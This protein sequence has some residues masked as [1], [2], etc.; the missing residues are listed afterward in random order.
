MSEG[1][2]TIELGTQTISSNQEKGSA[3]NPFPEDRREAM[4]PDEKFKK[5]INEQGERD[6][7]AARFMRESKKQRKIKIA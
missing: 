1:T 6:R 7:Q 3:Y 4:S 5:W 2:D